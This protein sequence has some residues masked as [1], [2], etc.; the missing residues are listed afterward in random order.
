ML[1]STGE[2]ISIA[3]CAMALEGM[4]LPVVSLAAWQVGIHTS[5][6]YSDAR[7]KKINPE[8]IQRELDKNKIVLVAGFQG[9]NRVVYDITS[10]PPATVEFE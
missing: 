9:V 6:T 2:Q 10:K 3:L 7:I 8:R 1:L 5:S 4:G